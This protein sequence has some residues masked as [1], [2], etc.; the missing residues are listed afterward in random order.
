LR[1]PSPALV[2]SLAALFVALGGTTYAAVGLPK[3]SVGSRQLKKNAVT[4][5][6]IKNGAVTARKI[7]KKGLE[8][9]NAAHAKA[10]DALGGHAARYF[11]PAGG[12]AAN[13]SE[14]GGSA[15]GSFQSRVTGACSGSSGIA[16]IAAAGTVTC[17]G[18]QFYS[19]RLVETPPL[20]GNPT[21]LTIPGVAHVVAL[22][23]SGS[24]AN[25][26]LENDAFGTTDLWA[27]SDT[28]YVGTNWTAGN[29]PPAATDGATFHL[30]EGSG[31][32]ARV[33]TVTIS[34]EATGSTCVYQGTAEVVDAN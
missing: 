17:A 22:N 10:A 21:F 24:A 32:G 34:T 1:A 26:E 16:A 27:S 13:S 29:T 4:S 3:N 18:V 25:A 23:C 31:P 33:I 30:G 20:T 2:I 9:P 28:N 14:L 6:K 11:L 8:V 7:D 5:A 12:T 15:A 19:G